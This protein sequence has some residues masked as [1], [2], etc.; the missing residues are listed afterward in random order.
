MD[1]IADEALDSE[2]FGGVVRDEEAFRIIEDFFNEQ[3]PNFALFDSETAQTAL[4]PDGTDLFFSDP[5]D[6]NDSQT[7]NEPPTNALV[8][9][10]Q[11]TLDRLGGEEAEE[12]ISAAHHVPPRSANNDQDWLTSVQRLVFGPPAETSTSGNNYSEETGPLE[13][14]EPPAANSDINLLSDNS[15]GQVR[16]QLRLIKSSN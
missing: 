5:H 8:P 15:R 4:H 6:S 2:V 7:R 9:R 16:V 10:G 3:F 1:A 12:I 14:S 11:M 13:M